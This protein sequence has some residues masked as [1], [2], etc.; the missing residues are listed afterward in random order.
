MKCD[1]V[2]IFLQHTAV[3]LCINTDI[4]G[5]QQSFSL[6]W[7]DSYW[8]DQDTSNRAAGLSAD[9][10]PNSA[11]CRVFTSDIVTA[12]HLHWSSW[13]FSVRRPY[14]LTSEKR[15]RLM[16]DH[17]LCIFYPCDLVHV[18]FQSVIFSRPRHGVSTGCAETRV[19]AWDEC[20]G[21]NR[22]DST[23]GLSDYCDVPRTLLLVLLLRLLN[24]HISLPFSNLSAGLRS[25]K[26]SNINLFL[27]PTKFLQAV[28]LAVLTIWSLFNPLAVPAPQLLSPFLGHRPSPRRKS[29]IGHSDT[30]VLH[31]VSGINSLIHS[32]SL[33]SHVSTHFLIHLSAHLCHHHHSHHLSLFHSRLKT[34]LF[35]K[36]FPP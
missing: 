28:N 30:R 6:H 7:K 10:T 14:G 33:A 15:N 26:A 36:S 34:Y 31:P 21:S 25:T 5:H 20:H 23:T 9:L 1:Y 12:T 32:V 8:V 3:C 13:V 27:L 19:P 17:N 29:Q 16:T 18:I 24:P 4:A 35:N 22:T 11:D 2:N